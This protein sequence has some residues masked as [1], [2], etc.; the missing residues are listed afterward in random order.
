MTTPSPALDLELDAETARELERRRLEILFRFNH[1]GVIATIA[2]VPVVA[3]RILDYQ[4]SAAPWIWSAAMIALALLRTVLGFAHANYH[5][6]L[7]D[8][9]WLWTM[10]ANA[11][12]TGLGWA[13]LATP[14]MNLH[15]ERSLLAAALL[16]ALIGIGNVSF[17]VSTRAF[18]AF[19][20]PIGLALLVG[21]R[22]VQH[23]WGLDITL[24]VVFF[25]GLMLAS[26][27]RLR[28]QFEENVRARCQEA[29]LR[30]RADA[31][32][33]AKS[34]FLA[35]MSHELRTPL[36]GM[37]G[38]AEML[39]QS[40]LP[41]S[42][43]APLRALQ[44]AGRSLT[45]L[46]CDVLDFARVDRHQHQVSMSVIEW[47]PMLQ[48]IA[49]PWQ[50][51]AEARGL[52]FELR[53]ASDL[54]RWISS[55]ALRLS[56]ILMHLLRNALKFTERGK[57][58]LRASS[59]GV[60][61]VLIEVIDTGCGV[62]PEHQWQIFQP[63]AGTDSEAVAERKGI[64]LGL[65]ICR[66]LASVLGG[67]LELDSHPGQ[68]STFR[69]HLPDCLASAPAP[70]P[71]ATEPDWS[72]IDVLVVEDNE[73]N[74]EVARL[75]LE[76]IGVSVRF[77][78]HG[79]AALAACAEAVP[80]LILMDCEMPEMD[81]LAA[82]REL[83]RQGIRVPILALTAHA[84]PENEQACRDAGMDAVLTKPLDVQ[85]L[86][87]RLVEILSRI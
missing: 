54:P 51:E 35:A 14:L 82:T 32:T 62:A 76:T 69:L 19:A 9:A 85:V 48:D 17:M 59:D 1:S 28:H 41:E 4:D 75:Y 23:Q 45:G 52:N 77:A 24:I 31:A 46:I 34:R 57:I 18:L 13:V 6:R 20:V 40:Q 74:R 64:G 44:M 55:D 73:L 16:I 11:A 58:E 65:S 79:R 47:R 53:L 72:S 26:N 87:A 56:Q 43:R 33:A 29:H 83:R 25:L 39:A 10:I 50:R 86:R 66:Q 67:S 81:G 2:L 78:E 80:H 5:S 68:G 84:M 37:M 3:W 61:G 27:V 70:I 7:S 42:S 60:R 12:L 15:T 22:L 63:F 71:R 30:R 36:N 8:H 21:L 49:L 38:M